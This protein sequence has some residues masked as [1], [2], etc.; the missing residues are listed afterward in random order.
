MTPSAGFVSGTKGATLRAQQEEGKM[1]KSEEKCR[2][3]K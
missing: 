3:Q 2:N 1:Q